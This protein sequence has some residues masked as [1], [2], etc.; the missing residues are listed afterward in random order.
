MPKSIAGHLNSCALRYY[1]E[2]GSKFGGKFVAK[3]AAKFGNKLS[4]NCTGVEHGVP[5]KLRSFLIGLTAIALVL[6]SAAAAGAVWIAANSPVGQLQAAGRSLPDTAALFVSRQS[7]L[8]LSLSVNPDRLEAVDLLSVPVNQRAQRRMEW[9]ELQQSLLAETQLNYQRDIQ[10]WLG[11]QALLAITTADVDRNAQ[12]G[13]QVGYLFAFTPADAPLARQTLQR[14]WQRHA[15]SKDRIT[16]TYAGV[17]ITY[18][19]VAQPSPKPTA[20][21]TAKPTAKLTA[22]SLTTASAVVG[23]R[24][25]LVA[26]SPKV[27]RDAINTVQVA[28]QSLSSSEA[29]AQAIAQLPKEALGFAFVNLPQLSAW[30]TGKS[31]S[32]SQPHT[33]ESLVASFDP[34]QGIAHTLLLAPSASPATASPSPTLTTPVKALRFI[35]AASTI[36]AAG[37]DVQQAWAQLQ[38]GLAGYDNVTEVLRQSIAPLQQQWEESLPEVL[39]WMKEDYAIALL[40]SLDSAQ[41]DWIAVTQRSSDTEAGLEKL[42]AIA[43]EQGS[44]IG[45]LSLETPLGTQTISAWTKLLTRS[46]KAAGKSLASLEA[47]VQGVH[48]T[49]ENYEIF[50]TSLEAID[51]ALQA[52]EASLLQSDKFR[53]AI[54]SFKT[55]NHGYFYLDSTVLNQVLNNTPFADRHL[56]L[57]RLLRQVNALSITSYGKS[58]IG[59]R[60]AVKIR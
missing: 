44:A 12:N 5:M 35:P 13:A 32:G 18:K 38:T 16:E 11:D 26:N 36:V 58:A 40:P 28:D 55:P 3:F 9:T 45:T 41:P 2:F 19:Q 14:F 24:L 42:N 60:G 50:A 7:P 59:Q 10:P 8:V 1:T 48:T 53:S 15:K 49:V 21:P 22:D 27:L 51:Q 33:Y 17:P 57:N 31:D 37:S 52:P 39:S 30:L 25:V 29:Y 54:G 43:L 47:Q 4:N 6:L 23:D 56:P 46:R 20:N 34:T